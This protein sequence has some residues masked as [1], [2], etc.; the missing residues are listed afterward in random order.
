VKEVGVRITLAKGFEVS[1]NTVMVQAVYENYKNNPQEF[2][3][4]VNKLGLNKPLGLPIKGRVFQIFLN[5]Q[6]DNG[7]HYP[8]HGWLMG[9]EFLL[10]LANFNII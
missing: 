1:S 8:C 5:L 6:I 10:H 9:M 4:R 2:I 3:D 7:V